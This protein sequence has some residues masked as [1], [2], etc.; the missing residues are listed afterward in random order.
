MTR[1]FPLFN[2]II[3]LASIPFLYFVIS[4]R[5]P[6]WLYYLSL[7]ILIGGSIVNMIWDWRAG[8]R[9]AVKIRLITYGVIITICLI[10]ALIFQK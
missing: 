9:K 4:D 7:S 1:P 5:E 8:K 2:L 10:L 6:N 3:F